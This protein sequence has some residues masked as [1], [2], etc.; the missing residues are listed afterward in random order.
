MRRWVV[1]APGPDFSVLDVHNGWVE[2]LRGLG[3]HV[4]DFNLGD[5]LAFYSNAYLATDYAA[6]GSAVSMKKAVDEDQAVELAVNGLAATLWKT[7]PDVLLVTTGFLVPGDLLDHARRH[8]TY[9]IVAHTEEP[10]E[11]ER[12]LDLA[13][14]ADLN[15]IN[16]PT[17]IERFRDVGPTFY[18]P[19]AYRPAAHHPC[20]S[21]MRDCHPQLRSDFAWVGTGF[22]SRRWF[23][24]RM[25]ELGAFDGLEV[26]ILGN[27]Q[28]T[29]DDS[30]LRPFLAADLSACVDNADTVRLYQ[31]TKAGINLYRRERDK[32][33]PGVVG[34][35]SM[36]PREVEMAAAGC[37][38]LRDPRPEG[39]EVLH[40]L[41]TFQDPEGA[42]EVLRWWLAHD[43][44]RE[45]AAQAAR[46]A[47]A[48]RT[49]DT[50]ARHLLRL[51]T[52]KD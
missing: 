7:R 17:H 12:E 5:R 30:P 16:D 40:M 32:D 36:G 26:E 29:A 23:F 8:G 48:D 34:G 31:H 18:V 27:W 38:F 49:F 33:H 28:G 10:Y 51:L 4:V 39:D 9:V 22:G 37:F 21:K 43:D 35:W 13:Q 44:E 24:E 41:P 50:H 14:H 45:K 15:L 42:V 11:V 46:E 6:D 3:E 19:Q 47:V 20:P 25:A 52:R 1:A 2:A